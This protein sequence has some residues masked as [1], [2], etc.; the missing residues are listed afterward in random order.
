MGYSPWSHKEWDMT[1]YINTHTHKRVYLYIKRVY[2]YIY[3]ISKEK[4]IV[5]TMYSSR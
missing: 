4:C 2:L 1:E 5:K 3:D